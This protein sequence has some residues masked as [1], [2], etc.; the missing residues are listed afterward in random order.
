M[1]NKFFFTI[2]R[3]HTGSLALGA[4]IIVATQFIQFV[5]KEIQQ[6]LKQKT[7]VLC[8]HQA[9][10]EVCICTCDCDIIIFSK[11]SFDF[12]E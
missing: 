9:Y 10:V 5:L 8:S 4:P 7:T 1:S 12:E 3:Y 2:Y 6:I 11:H